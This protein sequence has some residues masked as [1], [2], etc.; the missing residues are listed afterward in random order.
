MPAFP[1]IPRMPFYRPY[2][3]NYYSPRMHQ[4]NDKRIVPSQCTDKDTILSSGRQSPSLPLQAHDKSSNI[5]PQT[6]TKRFSQDDDAI[7]DLFGIK[8]HFDDILLICLIF[9]LYNEGV[10][11]EMLFISLIFLLLS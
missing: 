6:E 7:F 4:E 10:K 1:F 2:Y 9:F 11:D 5:E 3:R 8:L